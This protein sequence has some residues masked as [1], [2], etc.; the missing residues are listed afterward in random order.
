MAIYRFLSILIL[1]L[2]AGCG[3]PAS[4]KA[5]ETAKA[6]WTRANS[7]I[8]QYYN[9]NEVKDAIFSQNNHELTPFDQA[10]GVRSNRFIM[11]KYSGKNK[12]T[13]LWEPEQIEQ[14]NVASINGETHAYYTLGGVPQSCP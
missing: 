11:I 10:N 12:Y 9:Y 14:I 13:N 3:D 4:D 7:A 6:C 8:M 2:L 5:I 1:I